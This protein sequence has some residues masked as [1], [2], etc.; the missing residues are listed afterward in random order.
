MDNIILAHTA[1]LFAI[2]DN[3]LSTC[4][5]TY[6][7]SAPYVSVFQYLHEWAENDRPIFCRLMRTS[8]STFFE[9]V[10]R[11]KDGPSFHNN[12]NNPQAPAEQQ[13]ACAIFRFG[14]YGNAASIKDTATLAGV[15]TG[16]IVNYPE[17]VMIAILNRHDLYIKFPQD[18][19]ADKKKAK[20][21]VSVQSMLLQL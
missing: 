1:N 12:S 4:V 19:D 17:R 8:S 21:Y 5:L 14:H 20:E 10:K 18:G 2:E 3:I 7:P 6:R 13:I 9:I 15:S 11:L 16:S